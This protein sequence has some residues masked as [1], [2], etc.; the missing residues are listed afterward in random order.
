[1]LELGLIGLK[2]AHLG[3]CKIAT[4]RSVELG[5]CFA[6]PFIDTAVCVLGWPMWF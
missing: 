3:R 6:F 2:N 4:I 5:T 1:M